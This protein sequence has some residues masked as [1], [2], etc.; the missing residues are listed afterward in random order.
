MVS[1]LK[2]VVAELGGKRSWVVFSP[3]RDMA[4]AIRDGFPPAAV[5]DLMPHLA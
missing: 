4:K 5:K 1:E 2:A 3:D